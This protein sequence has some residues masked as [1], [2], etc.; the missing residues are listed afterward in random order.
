MPQVI[1]KEVGPIGY[2]LMGFTWRPEPTPTDQA[3]EALKAALESGLTLWNGAEFYGTPDCNSMTLMRAYFTKYPEDADKVTLVVKGGMDLATH[4][5]D[6]SP[7]GTR[8]SLDNIIKQL[9]GTKKLD[10]FAPSRRDH[11]TPLEV[12]YGVIQKEYIDTG[13][14][15]AV[16][17]SECRAETVHEA[18]KLARIGAAE[19]EL[20]MFSP[21]ILTNGVAKACAQHDIPILAY[22][23]MGRGILTGR[24]K[25]VADVQ[26]RGVISSFPRFQ[27]GAFEH[28][29]Q[30][31]DQVEGIAKA[32]GCTPGQLAIAWVRKHSNRP[33][34]P[35]IIPIPGATAASRVR[36]NAKLVDITEEEFATM[37]NLVEN[38]ETAGKRYP[39]H[40]PTNT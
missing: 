17:L 23:P 21:D 18:A 12:T 10:G 3:I 9:G 14:L 35:T 19:V 32:K 11:N 13:K 28:N 27:P 2:G 26:D 33:G 31:V 6:G 29:L 24:F 38:F 39:D 20:S 25:T 34:L 30:L 37:S 22:S 15:G 4:R 7:E 16:Y 40:I 5:L 36:E 1:G 8:R